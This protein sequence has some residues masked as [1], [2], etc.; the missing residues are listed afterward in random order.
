MPVFIDIPRREM[1]P[2]AE[3]C[4][5]IERAGGQFV[6]NG[7]SPSKSFGTFW[8]PPSFPS[9]DAAIAA[10]AD[11]AERN[12]VATVYMKGV[13]P[14]RPARKAGS[15]KAFVAELLLPTDSRGE[16]TE[17]WVV[18]EDSEERAIE[19]LLQSAPQGAEI[20]MPIAVLNEEVI[21]DEALE[22]GVPRAFDIR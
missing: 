4:L 1:P 8:A 12:V 15:M 6:V 10:S 2:E 22:P 11:F 5:V 17:Q 14:L 19:A 3:P 16:K 21:G 7:Y 18:L 9:L 13:R 20:L